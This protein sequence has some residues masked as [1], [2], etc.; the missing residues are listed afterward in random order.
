LLERRGSWYYNYTDLSLLNTPPT[1]S[2]THTHTHT[3]PTTH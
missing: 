2:H 1:P 3:H